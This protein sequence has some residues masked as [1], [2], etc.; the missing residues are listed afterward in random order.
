MAIS[1][2]DQEIE[3]G[4]ERNRARPSL[5]IAVSAH[6]SASPEQVLAAGYDFSERR[7]QIWG[8]VKTKRL[9]VHERGDTWAEV[10]EATMI[11]GVFWERCRYDWSQ[12]GT[13]T[14]TVRDSNV[15]QPGS[16]FE[17]RAIPRN[18]RRQRRRD[19][20][21]PQ[22]PQRTQGHDRAVHQPPRGQAVCSGGTCAPPS[23]RSSKRPQTTRPRSRRSRGHE[24]LGPHLRRRLRP[25]YVGA[26]EG[27]ATDAPRGADPPSERSGAG[28]RRRHRRQPSL[29]Q[30]HRDDHADRARQ[31][32]DAAPRAATTGTLSRIAAPTRSGRGS[33]VRRRQLRCRPSPP[34]CSA[35][36]TTNRERYA[37][38]GECSSP[39]AAY[40]SSSTYAPMT[41]V[42]PDGRTG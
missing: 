25:H 33:A 26:R 16:T 35:R 17:L 38:S 40:S 42:L 1:E 6:T 7:E 22:L 31:A 27:H 21:H 34:S 19:G 2:L 32:D 36:S 9:E 29:L 13:V 5:R 23:P 10:T 11:I 30:I 14:A 39:A 15:F 4:E 18:R 28:D 37:N 24:C 12:P 8:N 3:A 20:H 41:I